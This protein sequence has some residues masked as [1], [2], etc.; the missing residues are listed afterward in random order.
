[1]V[2]S[3]FSAMRRQFLWIRY[4]RSKSFDNV[5]PEPTPLC[6]IVCEPRL[7]QDAIVDLNEDRELRRSDN[8][9]SCTVDHAIRYSPQLG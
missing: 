9:L 7:R 6:V 5:S 1:M 8:C 3:K 4:P 2:P